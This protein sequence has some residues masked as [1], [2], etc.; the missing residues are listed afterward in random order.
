MMDTDEVI[1]RNIYQSG[2]SER[3]LTHGNL[4]VGG[5]DEMGQG[6][7]KCLP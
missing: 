2:S 7:L 5:R 1:T 6:S 3:G 4:N